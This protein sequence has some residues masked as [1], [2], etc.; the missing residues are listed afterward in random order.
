[1]LDFALAELKIAGYKET[2]IWVLKDN[3]RGRRFYEKN[4]F[5]IDGMEMELE[6]G[7]PLKCLRYAL[8]IH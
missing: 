4:G 1:M 6:F 8:I 3:M 7:K 2:T 5:I